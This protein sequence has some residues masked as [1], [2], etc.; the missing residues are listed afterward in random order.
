[1]HD[2]VVIGAGVI[3]SAVAR[4]LSR[5]ALDIVVLERGPD[6][7]TGTSKANSGIVHAGYDAVP[8]T[9]KAKYNIAGNPLFD[10]LSEELDFPFRRIGG[11]VLAF[12][13][14]EIPALELLR[15]RGRDNGVRDL[16]IID[17]N[18]LKRREPNIGPEAVAALAVPGSGIVCPYEMTLA[19]AENAAA[20]GVRFH[21][22]HPVGAITKTPGGFRL[23]T[24][25]GAFEARV[26]VNAA[27]L[28][29]DAVNNMLSTRRLRIVP[30]RGEYLLLD[31]SEGDLV[32]HTLFQLPGKMG[33]GVLLTPTVDGNLLVGPTAEDITDKS[34][35]S[36]TAEGLATAA[37]MA[38]R[39]LAAI[40]FSSVIA[41]FAGLRA[42]ETTRDDF[43]I[44]PC[45]DVPGLINAAGIESPGLTAAP[46]IARDIAA[47][48]SDLAKPGPNRSFT[49]LRRAAPC[50][51][52]MTTE[53]KRAA[54]ADDPNYGQIVCRCEN[55]TRAEILAALRGPLPARD[56]DGIKRRTRAGMGR[57]QAG[58]CSMRLPEIVAEELGI[59]VTGVT[60]CGGESRLLLSRSKTFP[61]EI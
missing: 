42:H 52:H 6:V 18:E 38:R 12:S 9:H 54:V 26:L 41:S 53:E 31:R 46:A 14:E 48:I 21:F 49:P 32:K 37:R 22:N 56:L 51:R 4:E 13:R 33:K 58:F 43:C 40:P 57:C 24:P 35:T 61:E 11:L 10:A 16:A 50:F 60:K 30:R 36:T 5:F 1:M 28:H 19:F 7:A 15:Q 20:N 55:V 47:M 45:P 17:R 39:D 34:D 27:G 8:G 25:D 3:G 2:V 44:G 29:A 23:E 59:P